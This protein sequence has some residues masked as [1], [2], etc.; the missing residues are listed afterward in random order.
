MQIDL[1]QPILQ[2]NDAIASELRERFAE[3]HVFVL[4]LLASTTPTR[5]SSR[6]T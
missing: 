3:N 5:R 4:D 1:K 2:K 6:R